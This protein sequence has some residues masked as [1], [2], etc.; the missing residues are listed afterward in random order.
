MQEGGQSFWEGGSISYRDTYIYVIGGHA[1]FQ[2]HIPKEHVLKRDCTTCSEYGNHFRLNGQHKG[3]DMVA[4]YDQLMSTHN[5]TKQLCALKV[6][7][8]DTRSSV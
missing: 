4:L 2:T 6:Q 3:G 5:I 8:R 7:P 1:C